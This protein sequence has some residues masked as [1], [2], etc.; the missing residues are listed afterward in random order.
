MTIRDEVG[1]INCLICH[2]FITGIFTNPKLKMCYAST[3]LHVQH[4]GC[5]PEE[6]LLLYDYFR[7]GMC[8]NCDHYCHLS[9]LVFIRSGSPHIMSKSP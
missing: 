7:I 2:V 1:M 8:K 9:V 4:N 6:I 5:T 3:A